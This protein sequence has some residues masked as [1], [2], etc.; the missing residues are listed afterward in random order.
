MLHSVIAMSKVGN[1]RSTAGATAAAGAL[2]V[3]ALNARSLALSALLGT[4]P[5][6]LPARALVAL[7]ELFEIAPGTTRTALS[8]LVASGDL[9]AEDGWYELAGGLLARQHSQDVGRRPPAH[10]WDGRWHTAISTD[11][12]RP[13]T[14]RRRARRVLSDAR[15]GELRPETWMRPANLPPPDAGSGWIVITGDLDTGRHA[16]LAGRLW[17][18]DRIAADATALIGRLAEID[19]AEHHDR[20]DAIPERFRTAASVLRFLRN[21]PL[22]PA[23]LVGAAW[24]V[25]ALRSDYAIAEASLQDTLRAFFRQA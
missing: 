5:P 8:R 21:E 20:F 7:G 24:P 6:R 18:L 12:H 25:D 17:D 3:R 22:L 2:D 11:E 4:H 15:F 1:N 13:V 10:A 19:R 23:E 14:E 16:E 9:V